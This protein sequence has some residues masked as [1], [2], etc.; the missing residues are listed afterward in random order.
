[1]SRSANAGDRTI[2]HL[3]IFTGAY[4]CALLIALLL[5]GHIT[6]GEP[7]Y[8]PLHTKPSFVS[9]LAT[10]DG[11]FYLD[12]S[13]RGY[14][15]GERVCAFYPLWPSLIRGVARLLRAD[16][17]V[18]ALALANLLGLLGW[19]LFYCTVKD[20]YGSRVA[21]WAVWSL[22][23]Y[24][25]AIFYHFA[26]SESL[27]LLLLMGVWRGIERRSYGLAA[28]SAFLLPLT[29]PVG[30]FCVIPVILSCFAK[31]NLRGIHLRF[32]P[33]TGSQCAG[34]N[35]EDKSD[36]H[37]DETRFCVPF[38]Q[39]PHWGRYAC[40]LIAIPA[41]WSCYFLIMSIATNNPL[42]GFAAQRFWGV[43]STGNI[44]DLH[45]FCVALFH[46]TAWHAYSG[47]M[48][49]RLMFIIVA[50]SVAE[51]WR[52][53]KSLIGWVIALA[54]L[55]ALSATF[56]SFTRYSSVAFPVFVAVAFHLAEARWLA[57]FA[58]LLTAGSV[59]AVLLWR[60]VHSLWAG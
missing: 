36:G 12:I 25:G 37:T 15:A 3:C 50:L 27:F 34:S 33:S 31:F 40:L 8:W 55:P 2:I 59:H 17:L 51:L 5:W 38:F 57:R 23:L 44:F 18:V 10:F 53:D 22:A 47:S 41:G 20:R 49:D 58:V 7:Y 6:Q 29:R 14:R 35:S 60:Y 16:S 26:Y 9:H 54:L 11:Y 45:K 1:M 56:T 32:V 19:S 30:V 13:E 48:L 4:W 28:A 42:E 43:N 46:P 21:S 24:P 52:R 39:Q